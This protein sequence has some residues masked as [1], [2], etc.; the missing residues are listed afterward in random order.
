MSIRIYQMNVH[1]ISVYQ[2]SYDTS[3]V[4]N[5]LDNATFKTSTQFYNTTFPSGML[6]TKAGSSTSDEQVENLTRKFN[7][8]Y[9]ACIGS[10]IYLLSTIVYLSIEEHMI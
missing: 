8:H 9:R 1:S 7:I 6:L 10:L 4:A 5:Y 2:D 3:I